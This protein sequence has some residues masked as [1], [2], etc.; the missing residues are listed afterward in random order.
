[1]LLQRKDLL[2]RLI[3][4]IGQGRLTLTTKA[5]DEA[6]ERI[7]RYLLV[8]AGLNAGYGITIGVGLF[9]IG[10]D[11][12]L[13]WG[14]L[15]ALLR[16]VPYV[17]PWIA[18]C[19][20]LALSLAVFSGWEHLFLVVALFVVVEL[21]SNM[22]LEPLM[23][24][25]NTGTSSVALLIAVAFWTWLWGPVGLVLATPLTVCL[26]VLAKYVPQLEFVTILLTDETMVTPRLTYYQR[27]LAKDQ[28]EAMRVVDEYLKKGDPEM[29]YDEVLLPALCSI[30]R[31]R[32][33]DEVSTEDEQFVYDA[34]RKVLDVL[35][36]R[37]VARLA[38]EDA[39]LAKQDAKEDAA[40]AAPAPAERKALVLGC[41]AADEADELALRMLRELMA[42][43]ARSELLVLDHSLLVGE[44]LSVAERDAASIV[45]IGAPPPGGLTHARYLIKRFRT[46]QPEVRVLVGRFG[47]PD[48]TTDASI[49]EQGGADRVAT[50]LLGARKIM[51]ELVQHLQFP[52]ATER[53]AKSMIAPA[54]AIA[55]A[56]QAGV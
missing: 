51:D 19:F 45:C 55:M 3:L 20:P 43:S 48:D 22:I 31:D 26:V 6:S 49:L 25:K 8:Q 53:T 37:R 30:K 16:F 29:I 4:V 12:A 34:T 40:L 2:D 13:L 33:R 28:D 1:M 32:D 50:T 41:P 7:S 54:D 52:V 5:L 15:A 9:F 39:A 14:C 38:K 17:G 18:A 36:E 56:R 35:A 27:L 23:Y 47:A 21:V 42:G 46:Q 44:A 24:G 11:Y 10:L